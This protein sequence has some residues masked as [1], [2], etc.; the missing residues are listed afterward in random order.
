MSCLEIGDGGSEHAGHVDSG[1]SEK[2]VVLR[3]SK[4]PDHDLGHLFI[5]DDVST[6]FIE[7]SHESVFP[8]VISINPGH[9]ER[10]VISHGNDL[11][12]VTRKIPGDPGDHPH[13]KKGSRNR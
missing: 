10:F 3:G 13:Y 7:L 11:G 2:L 1:M 6:L 8:P 5:G 4:G 9:P 12:Q